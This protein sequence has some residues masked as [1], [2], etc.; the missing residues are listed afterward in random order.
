MKT[1]C[2][3][4]L[5][6]HRKHNSYSLVCF[7]LNGQISLSFNL[8]GLFHQSANAPAGQATDCN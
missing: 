5:T 6:T 7:A 1:F 8:I 4:K 2:T 3:T